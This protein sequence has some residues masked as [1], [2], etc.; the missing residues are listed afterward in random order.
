MKKIIYPIYVLLGIVWNSSIGFAQ[1]PGYVYTVAG[2]GSPGYSGDG[3]LAVN[4][5]LNAPIAVC[6]DNVGN[7]YIADNGNHRV[8]KIDAVSKII[9]TVAGNGISGFSG[10]GG[11]ATSAKMDGPIAVAADGAGNIY[12]VTNGRVR[13]VNT[14]GIINTIAGGGGNAG[15]GGPAVN[16]ALDPTGVAVDAWGNIYISDNDRIRKVDVTGIITTIAGGG[17]GQLVTGAVAT[18]VSICT[19]N[20]LAVDANGNVYFTDFYCGKC[21]KVDPSGIVT[22]IAGSTEGFSG[23]GGL[24]TAAQISHPEG[25]SV[26]L[27]GN[28]FIADDGNHR[29]RKIDANTGIIST[30]IGTGGV[31][32]SGDSVLAAGAVISI[33]AR[34]YGDLTGNC[35]FAD[36]GNNRVRMITS[37]ITVAY[38]SSDFSIFINEFCSGSQLTIAT[39]NYLPTYHLTTYFGDN[40]SNSTAV[41]SGYGPSTGFATVNH[42][43]SLP[44]MYTLKTILWDGATVLDSLIY[45]YDYRLCNDI[46][47]KYYKDQNAD[48]MYSANVDHSITVPML[49]EVDSN[50]IVVDTIS[51]TSGFYYVAYGAPGDVY[52]FK[53][54]PKGGFTASCPASGTI[55]DTLKSQLYNLTSISV[56]FQCN[57][58][59][60]FDLAA[61]ITVRATGVQNQRGNIYARNNYC[62]PT[63][64]TLTLNFSPKY[65]YVG[66]ANPP[67]SSIIGNS[68]IWNLAGLSATDIEP[69]KISY[70]LYCANANP[71]TIGDTVQEH[72]QIG[73]TN[74]DVDATNNIVI[75]EDTVKASC[76]PNL[77]EVSPE[78]RISAGVNLKYRIE[79]EN[80]GNDTAFNIYVLDTLPAQVDAK[81]LRIVSSTHAMY[82]SQYS[83]GP[84]NIVKFDFPN[85]N[86]L[87][88]SHHDKCTGTFTYTINSKTGLP[89]GTRIDHKAGIYFDDNGL[90]ETNM[91]ENV[92]GFPASVSNVGAANRVQVYPNPANNEITIKSDNEIFNSL[93][94]TNAMGQEVMQHSL[95]NNE[96][97]VNVKTLP[98]GV[99]YITLKGVD[100]NVV[101]K[102]VKM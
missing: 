46:F 87:D 34:L 94:V 47:V 10:D 29:I 39:K 20:N 2:N 54:I 8:R 23:D 62:L 79:F 11:P 1:Q 63:N 65:V 78:G 13:K 35:Y 36:V 3:G 69:Q 7:I 45:T 15:D 61:D 88:S 84:Y 80:V 95:N 28:I 48:C 60:S 16:A 30:I 97:K 14:S 32:Y 66:G 81:S 51:S 52:S 38:T 74:G 83:S 99:Y 6:K 22:I 96:T 42:S 86:L 76:D 72:I 17:V 25:I 31:G 56:G 41:I 53:V 27:P 85:I 64:A 77:I 33:G 90:V 91:V 58:A 5:A 44:G 37:S 43:Y 71:L 4:A 101:K 24:A 18:N 57:A 50:G 19:T 59:A 40:T 73:P 82:T 92:I 89:Y 102:F 9:T 68:L 100:G 98:A 70:E 21:S 55:T 75:H 49:T 26:D 12:I 67:P 93:T